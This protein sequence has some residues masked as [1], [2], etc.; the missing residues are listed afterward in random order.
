MVHVYSSQGKYHSNAAKSPTSNLNNLH[1][2]RTGSNKMFSRHRQGSTG[3]GAVW[4]HHSLQTLQ[5]KVTF[6]WSQWAQ[7]CASNLCSAC[8]HWS[9]VSSCSEEFL[10]A[11]G[12]L[13]IR[14]ALGRAFSSWRPLLLFITI[15]WG[16][17]L[18]WGTL[19]LF[20][21]IILFEKKR[22]QVHDVWH[23]RY[24]LWKV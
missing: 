9:F 15:G 16:W 3:L 22:E 1:T 18:I 13:C 10:K 8:L 21:H 2:A 5:E 7:S 6:A 12:V 11:R 4:V 19:S 17:Q 20:V 14:G 23:D 24:L